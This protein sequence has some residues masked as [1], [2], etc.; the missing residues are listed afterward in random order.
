MASEK[1]KLIFIVDDDLTFQIMMDDHLCAT[2]NYKT[3]IFSTGEDCLENLDLAPDVIILDYHLDGITKE[4]ANGMEILKSIKATN[5][6]MYVII[7]SSQER[8]GVAAQMVFQGA[9]EYLVKDENAFGKTR[10]LI[11][12]FFSGA[13]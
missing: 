10:E 11:E 8:F 1:K 5:P 9:N 3:R 4:A 12:G 6:E 2:G 13:D 7:L